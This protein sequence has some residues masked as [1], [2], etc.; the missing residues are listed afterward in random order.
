MCF[1]LG[2]AL[3]GLITTLL[4]IRKTALEFL[5]KYVQ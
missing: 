4:Y 5:K 3:G 1:L 2:L